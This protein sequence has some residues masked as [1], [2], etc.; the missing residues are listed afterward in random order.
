MAS[1]RTV[2]WGFPH[3]P[4]PQHSHFCMVFSHSGLGH[5]TCYCQ[6]DVRELDPS[7]VLKGHMQIRACDLGRFPLKTLTPCWGD[8]AG[9]RDVLSQPSAVPAIPAEVPGIWVKPSGD[10]QPQ[11]SPQV[12]TA[13]QGT[14]DETSRRN[15]Q[16][17]PVQLTE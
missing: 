7:R 12:T 10:S 8:H 5:V 1:V 13:T 16:L 3:G 2:T 15:F 6:R 4:Y 17:S 9:V 14:P 11:L